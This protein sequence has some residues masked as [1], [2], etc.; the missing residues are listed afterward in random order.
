VPE[1]IGAQPSAA[2]VARVAE[3]EAEEE[4]GS[5][6]VPVLGSPGLRRQRSGGMSAVKAVAGRAPVRVT[7][8]L[9]MGQGGA[10]GG[11]DARAPFLGLEGER[12]GRAL[13]GNGRPFWEGIS[14]G[15]GGE[16]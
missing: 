3:R 10:V 7:Q 6:G 11:G 15:G 1:L 16:R 8:G 14:Q 9:E 13:E 4:K 12:G 2:P 5:T